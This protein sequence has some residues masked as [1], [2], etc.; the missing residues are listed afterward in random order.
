MTNRVRWQ[1]LTV[2]VRFCGVTVCRNCSFI[3]AH[4]LAWCT[5]RSRVINSVLDEILVTSKAH[6]NTNDASVNGP[7]VECLQS[8]SGKSHCQQNFTC[9]SANS[10]IP[11]YAIC[12]GTCF[13][14][15]VAVPLAAISKQIITWNR[16]TATWRNGKKHAAY[17]TKSHWM[18]SQNGIDFDLFDALCFSVWLLMYHSK[19]QCVRSLYDVDILQLWQRI[20]L[21]H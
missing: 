3:A 7:F 2:C 13:S 8:I 17:D 5:V 21:P 12:L 20:N 14:R 9:L 1:S 16:N 18:S 15:C 10:I 11:D 4:D 19:P 6:T